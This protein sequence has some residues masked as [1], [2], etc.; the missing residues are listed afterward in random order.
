MG[1]ATNQLNS[2]KCHCNYSPVLGASCLV[3]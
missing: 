1:L 3:L 2:M